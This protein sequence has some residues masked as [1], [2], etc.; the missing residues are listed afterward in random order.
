MWRCRA[1][2]STPDGDPAVTELDETDREVRVTVEATTR[3]LGPAAECLDVVELPLEAPI[4]DRMLID[5][6][7]GEA[8]ELRQGG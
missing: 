6:S 3:P 8:V 7:S 2:R 1:S 4:G 5:G